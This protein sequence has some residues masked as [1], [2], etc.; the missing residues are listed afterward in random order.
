MH[1]KAK[2]CPHCGSD[3]RTGWSEAAACDALDLPGEEFEYDEFAKREFEG[4]EKKA[5]PVLWIF[6]AIALLIMMAIGL[7]K[8]A[9]G[10]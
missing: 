5:M 6:V 9:M 3:E 4:R 1:T 8:S 10:S 7:L 2:A